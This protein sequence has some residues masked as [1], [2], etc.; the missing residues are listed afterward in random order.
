MKL[1]AL[2]K[3]LDTNS[4]ELLAAKAGISSAYLWQIATQ[5]NGRRPSIDVIGRLIRADSRL[6]AEDLVCEFANAQAKTNGESNA[7]P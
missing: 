6:K 4:R 7:R 2:Y 3:T 5:W 1:S